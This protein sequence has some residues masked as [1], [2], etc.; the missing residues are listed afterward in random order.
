MVKTRDAQR[1][2]DLEQIRIALDTYY[3]DFNR[4][5]NKKNDKILNIPWGDP[6]PSSNGQFYMVKLPKDP[7]AS[8]SYVYDVPL[9]GTW[10]RLYAKLERCSDHQ[11]FPGVD[12]GNPDHNY[13][14]VSPNVGF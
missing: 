14:V 3:N 13:A 11:N 7:R 1:K 9:D 4:Y 5:P 2:S 10:Y 12:C 6:W 8:Q